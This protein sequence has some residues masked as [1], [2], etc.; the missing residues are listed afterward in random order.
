MVLTRLEGDLTAH[1]Q[2]V[3]LA[4]VAVGEIRILAVKTLYCAGG[5]SGGTSWPLAEMAM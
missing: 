2:L 5:G 1:V 4:A 3:A